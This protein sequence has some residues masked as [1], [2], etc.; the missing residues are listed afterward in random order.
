MRYAILV[1]LLSCNGLFAQSS[2]K[3]QVDFGVGVGQD[4]YGLIF[5][6]L[7]SG[8]TDMVFSGTADYTFSPY[9]SFGVAGSFR[10][11]DLVF[12][13][14]IQVRNI[15]IRPMLHFDMFNIKNTDIYLGTRFSY[16]EWRRNGELF[17]NSFQGLAV[18]SF[19]SFMGV[20]YYIGNRLGINYEIAIG[21]PYF[22]HCGL[23]LRLG[24]VRGTL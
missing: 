19:Q 18:Y 2:V 7:P 8:S 13:T 6:R 3:G 23:K 24:P 17:R 4:L 16:V 15:G 1:I 10:T 22:I 20:T 11:M 21:A 9:F 14:I 5:D 12:D